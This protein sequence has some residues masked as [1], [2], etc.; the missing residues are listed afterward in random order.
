MSRFVRASG[1]VVALL[2]VTPAEAATPLK[3]DFGADVS[4]LG[5]Y[6]DKNGTTSDDGGAFVS[7]S[8]AR[9]WLKVSTMF[10]NGIQFGFLGSLGFDGAK[11]ALPNRGHL[12]E[13]YVELK[14]AFGTVQFG[15]QN[16]VAD[17]MR[18]A[19][20]SPLDPLAPDDVRL[21]AI[22]VAN[23]YN[24]LSLSGDA[25][26]LV[27]LTPRIAGFQL[28]AS[29]LVENPKLG[30]PVHATMDF[31]RGHSGARGAAEAGLNYTG[32][33]GDVSLDAAAT[34]YIDNHN[35]VGQKDP[36]AY[37][38]GVALGLNG[39]TLGG[40]LTQ[41]SNINH[42]TLYRSDT[43][44]TVWSAGVTYGNGPWLLGGAYSHGADDPTGANNDV[45]YQ[46]YVLGIIYFLNPGISLGLGVQHDQ[47][48]PDPLGLVA[49]SGGAA[50]TAGKDVKGDAV[51][52]ETGLKF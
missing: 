9:P 2:A 5:G 43:K 50:V 45:D 13:A 1:L 37:N 11:N 33:I 42:A 46:S 44:T 14:T 36:E 48:K 52:V 31:D 41:G 12:D 22:E 21:D 18:L 3:L 49:P 39:W 8:Y 7:R 17:R 15:R 34:Y 24:R 47:G 16:G 19:T 38:L 32:K 25:G 6:A 23:N 28:G 51:F 26:K 35:G 40:N 30:A 29:Y 27:Y 4:A 20:P 10:D